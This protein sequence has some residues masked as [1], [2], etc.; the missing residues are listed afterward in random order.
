MINLTT[1]TAME[2]PVLSNTM[3]KQHEQAVLRETAHDLI[4]LYN[5]KNAIVQR[6]I[7]SLPLRPD[8]IQ[9]SMS[10][11]GIRL[12]RQRKDG[13]D[14]SYHMRQFALEF[15][16]CIKR[17]ADASEYRRIALQLELFC[18]EYLRTPSHAQ[19]QA[20]NLLQRIAQDAR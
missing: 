2:P 12:L 17:S 14:Y 10:G 3:I 13:P 7:Q 20:W 6:W 4:D 5:D 9:A 19:V 1:S 11:Q 16:R 8:I 15:A 18:Y